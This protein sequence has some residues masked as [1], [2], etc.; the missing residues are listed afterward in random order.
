MK[1]DFPVYIGVDIPEPL[2]GEVTGIRQKLETVV[3]NLPN[4]VA[5]TGSSGKGPIPPGTELTPI[6]ERLSDICLQTQQWSLRFKDVSRFPNTD[7]FI[8]SIVD[9]KPF[10]DFHG[11]L[12]ETDISFSPIAYPYTPHCVLRAGPNFKT[13]HREYLS[14]LKV[15]REKVIMKNVIAVDFDNRDFSCRLMGKFKLGAC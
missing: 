15:P 13:G 10:D 7:I 9:R 12:S 2:S 6:L 11:K 4:M 3:S 14:S 1:P 5:L 8:L